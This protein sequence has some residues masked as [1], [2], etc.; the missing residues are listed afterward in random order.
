MESPRAVQRNLDGEMMTFAPPAQKPQLKVS[1]FLP[2]ILNEGCGQNG[3]QR[4]DPHHPFFVP[5]LGGT[6]EG[7]IMQINPEVL[8]RTCKNT[9]EAIL[10]CLECATKGTLYR[11]GR[12][13]TAARWM[14][15]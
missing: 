2:D 15:L 7:E 14:A 12:Q 1:Q 11:V 13:T 3:Q 8:E 9:I 10:C 6:V 5:G 4:T